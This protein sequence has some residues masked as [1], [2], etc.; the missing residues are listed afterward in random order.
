MDKILTQLDSK[1][2]KPGE[3]MI[4][5]NSEVKELIFIEQ[6]KCN[7]YGFWPSKEIENEFQKLLIVRLVEKSWYGDAQILL[8]INSPFQLEAGE[9]R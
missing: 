1:L 4:Q 7:L 3:T 2:Y 9:I 8:N 5:H 6:G